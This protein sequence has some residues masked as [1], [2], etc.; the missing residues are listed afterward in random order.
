MKVICFSIILSISNLLIAQSEITKSFSSQGIT[1]IHVDGNTVFNISFHTNASKSIEIKTKIEGENS[2]NFILVTNVENETL[3]VA[4]N[5]QPLFQN[6]NDKLSAH[7]AIAIELFLTIPKNLNI[8]ATSDIA[9]VLVTGNYRTINLALNAGN[10]QLT[11][12]TGNATIKTNYGNILVN[13]SSYAILSN[14]L[15]AKKKQFVF[16]E[17]TLNLSTVNGNIFVTNK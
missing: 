13:T 7:K 6:V 15:K 2:E 17:G 12:F 8:Q 14:K 3:F 4:I 5:K 1:N 16:P 10:C 11:N 9:S